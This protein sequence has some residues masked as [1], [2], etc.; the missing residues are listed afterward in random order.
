MWCAKARRIIVGWSLGI[1]LH[2]ITVS[3][4][5]SPQLRQST[6]DPRVT[7]RRTRIEA[8]R[9]VLNRS[10]DRSPGSSWS[11]SE[12]RE[13]VGETGEGGGVEIE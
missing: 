2:P 3:I 6:H 7:E 10:S 1:S 13:S 9:S 11:E 12:R 8:L 5:F 4:A